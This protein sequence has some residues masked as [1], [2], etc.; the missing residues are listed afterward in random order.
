MTRVR[1]LRGSRGRYGV[2]RQRSKILGKGEAEEMITCGNDRHLLDLRWTGAAS[3]STP[4][5]KYVHSAREV[6]DASTG[7]ENA[8]AGI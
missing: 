8:R 5:G 6:K 2:L 3:P 1:R 7:Q 4:V